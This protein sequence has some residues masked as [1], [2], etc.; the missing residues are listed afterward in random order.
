MTQKMKNSFTTTQMEFPNAMLAA[1]RGQVIAIRQQVMV[2]QEVNKISGWG[3]PLNNWMKNAFAIV[4][5]G[6][7]R[8]LGLHGESVPDSS[9]HPSVA[10]SEDLTGDDANLRQATRKTCRNQGLRTIVHLLD[11]LSVKVTHFDSRW[12]QNGINQIEH[13]QAEAMLTRCFTICD[14]YGGA[15]N[16]LQLIS[17]INFADLDDGFNHDATHD[18]VMGNTDVGTM[19]NRDGLSAGG[20]VARQPGT[21]TP[22][23][24]PNRTPIR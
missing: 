23:P 9:L 12:I 4:T 19:A 20:P 6:L 8:L 3:D 10:V 11:S 13:D 1:W 18:T 15:A 7:D 2:S 21:A 14:H 24:T 22:Q 5:G 17:G 16:E